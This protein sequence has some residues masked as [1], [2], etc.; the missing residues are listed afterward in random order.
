ML[1]FIESYVSFEKSI[2]RNQGLPAAEL[3]GQ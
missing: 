3:T 2:D 1:N